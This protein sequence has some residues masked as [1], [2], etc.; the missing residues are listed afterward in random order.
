MNFHRGV[1]IMNQSSI[2]LDRTAQG[3]KVKAYNGVDMGEFYMEVDGYYVYV[4]ILRG[5]FWPAYMLRAVA[6]KLDEVN[7]SWDKQVQDYFN[8]PNTPATTG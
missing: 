3:Y 8:E 4:P 1:L 6:D 5:G 7:A 2:T